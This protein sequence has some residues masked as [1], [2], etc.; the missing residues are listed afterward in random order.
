MKKIRNSIFE[1]NSSSSHSITIDNTNNL[2]DLSLVNDSGVIV[3]QSRY[4]GWEW[5]SYNDAYTKAQYLIADGKLDLVLQAIRKRTLCTVAIELESPE[6]D[7]I[8]YKNF[9]IDHQSIGTTSELDTLE[10]VDNFIFNKNCYLRTGNDNEDSPPNFYDT[11]P[12]KKYRLQIK[13]YP[14]IGC[15][16]SFSP[17]VLSLD[18]TDFEYANENSVNYYTLKDLDIRKILYKLDI[19]LF[20]DKNTNEIVKID[21]WN[22]YSISNYMLER[23]LTK[24]SRNGNSDFFTAINLEEKSFVLS[25]SK[26]WGENSKTTDSI[27]LHYEIIE[28]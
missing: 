28:L 25:E 17:E 22:S 16:F 11:N 4:F 2:I 18:E 1:T 5:E 9:G 24:L 3:I 10:K 8:C 20:K 13:E 23:T 26:G 15:D 21:Y 14:K 27:T 12:N 6:D 7:I 19:N